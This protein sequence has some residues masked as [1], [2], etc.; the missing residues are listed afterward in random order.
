MDYSI[1]IRTLGTAGEKYIKLAKSIKRLNKKPK[2]VII[3]IPEGY[4]IP[5]IE[6]ENQRI[7]RS[8]KG[9]LLQRIV[10]FE[11]AT[12]NYVLL[13]DDDIEFAENLV[14][15]LS[16]PVLDGLCQ[17]SFPIYE[18]LLLQDKA[19]QFVSAMTL[20]SIPNSRD[21][22]NFVRFISSGGT[23]YNSKLKKSNKYLYSESAPGMC[24]FGEKEILLKVKL[25]DELW[26]DKTGYALRE[27]AILIYKTYLKNY[28][29]IG[30]Q[31]IDIVHLDGGGNESKRN[32]KAAY[33]N[34]YNHLLFWKRFIYKREDIF[35]KKMIKILF[36]A[37]NSFSG[38]LYKT[39]IYII[40]R[41][42]ELY[43]AS[44][45]GTIDAYKKILKKD[46]TLWQ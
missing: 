4:E 12:T 35:Y 17:L 14:E 22:E 26:I 33:A 27:D 5:K 16:K 11:E 8:E 25:R 39:L 15:E 2:E 13:L 36:I 3:V 19:R 37:Y 23:I 46:K 38:L 34:S 21:K 20:S 42:F 30:V 45:L 6:I 31:N 7:V 41:D 10:G 43:K 32:I 24:V 18:D 9:M 1:C 29:I 40:K 44:V 28:K